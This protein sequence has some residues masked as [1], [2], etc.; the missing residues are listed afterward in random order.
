MVPGHQIVVLFVETL[1]HCDNHRE[2]YIHL[3]K[4]T[5]I[6]SMWR[7]K[8]FTS[9]KSLEIDWWGGASRLEVVVFFLS[10]KSVRIRLTIHHTLKF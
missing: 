9:W 8:V 6:D 4:S 7:A 1:Q 5:G 2:L 10:Q 3:I